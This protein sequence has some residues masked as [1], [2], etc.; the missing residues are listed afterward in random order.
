[1]KERVLREEG[2]EDEDINLIIKSKS[3]DKDL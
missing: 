2:A 1:M 3:L